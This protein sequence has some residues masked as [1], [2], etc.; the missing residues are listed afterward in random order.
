MCTV[1]D[2]GDFGILAP[3]LRVRRQR[4]SRWHV[5]FQGTAF[6]FCLPRTHRLAHQEAAD[7][8]GI[9]RTTAYCYWTYAKAA[10][11]RALKDARR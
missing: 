5:R 11:F 4:S 3:L 9:S 7:R 2:H 6:F 8:L 1:A 10:L